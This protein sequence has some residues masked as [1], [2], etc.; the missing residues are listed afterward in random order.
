MERQKANI[1]KVEDEGSE[2]VIFIKDANG[3]A[4]EIRLDTMGVMSLMDALRLCIREAAPQADP[5]PVALFDDIKHIQTETI[6]E[7]LYF[8]IFVS[9]RVSH[10]Y[11]FDTRTDLGDA[12]VQL[13]EHFAALKEAKAHKGS[14]QLQ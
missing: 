9:E 5:G 3:D 6:G 8:R 10:A 12:L 2:V 11:S 4:H 13:G 14:D 1:E 7:T